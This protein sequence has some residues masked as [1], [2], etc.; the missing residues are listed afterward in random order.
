MAPTDPPN[1]PEA[2]NILDILASLRYLLSEAED[3]GLEPV[4]EAI[5]RALVAAEDC[6]RRKLS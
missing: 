3:V 1:P 6:V 2:E 4:A 5:Q